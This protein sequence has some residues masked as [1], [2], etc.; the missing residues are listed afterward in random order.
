MLKRV[1]SYVALIVA[2]AVFAACA[3]VAKAT[4]RVTLWHSYRGDEERALVEIVARYERTHAQD[5]VAIDLLAIPFEAYSAKLR[6]AIPHAHGPD[7]FIDT[8]ERLGV[9]RRDELVAPVGAAFPEEDAP[10]YDA[11]AVA[12]MTLDGVRYGVPL[13]SKCLALFVNEDLLPTTPATIEEIAALRSRLPAGTYPIVYDMTTA[14][15]HAPFLHAFGGAMLDADGR[16]AFY[17]ENVARSLELVRG[18][19]TNDDVPQE[20]SSALVTQL[21]A[22]G[23]AATAIEGP[24]LVGDLK[25][26]VRYR[27][28]PLP[29]VAAAGGAKMRPFLSVEGIM[30]TP[31]GAAKPAA[32]ALARWLGRDVESA[33]VR[34]RVG[35]QVV[36]E[37][38]AWAAMGGGTGKDADP[39]LRAFHEAAADALPMPTST[40]LR[41]AWVPANQAILKVLRGEMTPKEALDEAKHR[42]EDVTRPLPPPA[43]PAP[44]LML[45]GGLLLAGAAL[46]V[47][48]AR[49]HAEGG[50]L[51]LALR[52][53]LPAYAYVAHAVV[54]V[55]L[56]VVLP[57]AAGA[58]TSL[59]AGQ[60]DRLR[61]V[62]LANYW[63]ILSARGGPLLA[64]G[65]FYMTLLV[66]VAW[67]L[68]N[69]AL[70]LALGLALG[71][72][73]S[74]P[75][76]RLRA[77]YRVL[78]I[79]PWAVPSYVTALAWKG[80]FHRQFGA[81]NALLRAAGAEPVSWFAHFSTAFAAN[82][83]TNTWL[84]FPFMMVVVLGAL[85]SIPKDVLEAA[86][87][88]GATRWQRF[89]LVTLP[90][91]G[92]TLLPAIVLGAVWTF[93]MFNV[94][95]L[96]SGGDPDETTDILVSEAY[97]W[98]FTRDAQY[99][100]AAA[101]AVLI[102]LL[103][104]GSARAFGRRVGGNT[105][106]EAA[107]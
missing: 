85:T 65:S 41:A 42:F 33:L 73:L 1:R 83:A 28:E 4:E 72:A 67:T 49:A 11:T 44:L 53:S 94:V 66:T 91:L 100:Y 13:S 15:F 9:Y 56:L 81:V 77:V 88:D 74:R 19:V 107:L 93:N 102:F 54:A 12:A 70:H 78:L 63:G 89:R 101:Y 32:I 82:V 25:T 51:R 60:H 58:A 39:V 80:M 24:W 64:H 30:A 40:A 23:H 59:F 57:L 87:V 27:V 16:F 48:R 2:F 47:R 22:T 52:R 5:G 92:P 45:V 68:V 17:G 98:A 36:T 26:G 75:I 10:L 90:L 37:Q 35:H 18:L 62:G 96:V 61:Y 97:R 105:T 3:R 71:L 95:F 38:A 103:L 84:G 79:L 21:F 8:H 69:V 34:A 7:L 86:E 99:G 76:L 29:R 106:S 55:V 46:G 20:P 43:S 50:E 14:F 104:A 31:E 6:A